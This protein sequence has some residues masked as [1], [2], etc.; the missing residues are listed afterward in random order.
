M[1]DRHTVYLSL[2]TNLGRRRQNLN[3]AI[4]LIGRQVGEVT[5]K[6]DFLETEPWG[7]DSEN[8][9]LNACVC[10]QTTLTPRQLLEVTQQIERQ[11]GRV[12]T[13][14]PS[15]TEKRLRGRKHS[16]GWRGSESTEGVSRVYHDRVIDIDIL[17]YDDLRVDEPDLQIPH[18]LM[19]QREFVMQPLRQISCSLWPNES[20]K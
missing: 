1:T 9:F 4:R 15:P 5:R 17:L 14:E 20:D 12:K 3:R 10:V 2:G 7:F 11:M 16:S 6:S 19:R 18:P 13:V 8:P